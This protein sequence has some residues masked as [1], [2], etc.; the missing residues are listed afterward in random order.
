MSGIEF[1]FGYLLSVIV[2]IPLGILTGW[3]KRLG[4]VVDPFLNALNATP[5]VA[6]LP[7]I[8]IWLGIGVLSKIGIIFLGAVFPIT[9]NVRDGIKTTPASLL[10][11]AKSFRRI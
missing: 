2:A 7:L 5:R 6:L 11:A 4:Y 9:I 1:F 10:N 3:N 8:I